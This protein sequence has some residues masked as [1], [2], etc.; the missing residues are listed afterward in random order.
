MYD[1][2]NA[3]YCSEFICLVISNRKEA[4]THWS[5]LIL[6]WDS[7]HGPSIKNFPFLRVTGSGLTK[8][9][10]AVNSWLSAGVPSIYIQ[11]FFLFLLNSVTNNWSMYYKL[12]LTIPIDILDIILFK[13][14]TGIL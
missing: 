10:V 4:I 6:S 2:S 14:E 9:A 1:S 5:S 12:L 3:D 7:K 13:R 11:I 8:N